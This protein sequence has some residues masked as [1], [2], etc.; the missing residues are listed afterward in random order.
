MYKVYSFLCINDYVLVWF[1]MVYLSA[2]QHLMGYFI[3][4]FDFH[5]FRLPTPRIS[6][7]NEVFKR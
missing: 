2:H 7:W 1:A 6:A 4:K 5:L 3:P